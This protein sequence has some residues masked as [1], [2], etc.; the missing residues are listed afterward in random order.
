MVLLR[1]ERKSQLQFTRVIITNRFVKKSL[2]RISLEVDYEAVQCMLIKQ[3]T[4]DY[5]TSAERLCHSINSSGRMVAK[6]SEQ[7]VSEYHNDLT[8][9]SIKSK[10]R[11]TQ[12]EISD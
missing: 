3:I 2:N 11:Q 6:I 4:R 8:K 7:Y 1:F 12:R 9:K 10:V 5:Y